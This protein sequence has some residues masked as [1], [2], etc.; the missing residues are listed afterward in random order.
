MELRK[1]SRK[2]VQNCVSIKDYYRD[3]ISAI[4]SREAILVVEVD[5]LEELVYELGVDLKQYNDYCVT[6]AGTTIDKVIDWVLKDKS[7]QIWNHYQIFNRNSTDGT[8]QIL[9]LKLTDYARLFKQ[10]AAVDKELRE[11]AQVRMSEDEYSFLI[12][13]YYTTKMDYLAERGLTISLGG[14]L[15][16]I[17][18]E[19][20]PDYI[21]ITKEGKS[22][23]A[24]DWAATRKKKQQ[25]IEA[26]VKLKSDNNPN[27]AKWHIGYDSLPVMMKLV[28]Y[29]S[30]ELY[31]TLRAFVFKVKGNDLYSSKKL[32]TWVKEF[33]GAVTNYNRR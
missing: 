31:Q 23:I 20:L 29:K 26:G 4:D 15:G 21:P 1:G 11:I 7:G 30:S 5:R 18:V 19:Y 9:K 27:G 28:R 12:N 25:L 24:V 14:K 17:I 32:Y 33:P 6:N 22:R 2:G 8:Y 16:K 3:F 10:L 13:A